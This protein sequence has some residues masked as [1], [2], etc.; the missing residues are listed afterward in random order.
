[1]IYTIAVIT[2]LLSGFFSGIEIAFVS[3]NRLK[4]ELEK[5]QGTRR[6]NLL[7]QFFEKPSDFLGAMLIG[8]TIALA[9]FTLLMERIL[10][11]PITHSLSGIPDGISVVLV[12]LIITL[13]ST[14][15][16]LIF[17]EFIP[18][19]LFR[20]NPSSTL[21]F[22]AWPLLI[23]K[24]I[25]TPLVM[26]M[27]RLSYAII[28]FVLRYKTEDSNKVFT[29]V[30]LEHYINDIQPSDQEDI[31][32]ELFK[33]ALYLNN[34][35]VTEC[36]L[37]RTEIVGIDIEDGINALKKEFIESGLSR[38]II[39]KESLDD[40]LGYV[41]HQQ[42]L[43]N[44]EAIEDLAILPIPVVPEVVPA[45]DLMNRLIKMQLSMACV[46]DE[47]GGTAGICTLEDILEELVGEIE[48]EH[49]EEE[50]GE[51][52]IGQGLYLFSGRLEVDY[53]NEKYDLGL[54][55]G[56]Y[57]T[58]SG[59]IVTAIETIPEEGQ[60]INLDGY[61]FVLETVSETKIESI[62]V[63]KLPEE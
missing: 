38:I 17:G 53:L 63:R 44:P 50:H 29:R 49:D 42:M 10:D 5:N 13:I 28:S 46:V 11:M 22:F 33:N 39:Y 19:I 58:I 54:S 15:I 1:M 57:N 31:D 32:T 43:S 16:V 45:R 61:E 2:L 47:F 40:I 48:D 26:V 59:Y 4:V 30:D 37:P 56:D 21:L 8:N 18:K 24:F 36:M 14:I 35:R 6:G 20:L 62:R 3:A 7:A 27:V 23:L 55:E 52:I 12:P 51:K 34:I 60:R 9:F 41:H 25:L